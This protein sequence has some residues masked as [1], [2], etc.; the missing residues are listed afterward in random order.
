[1]WLNGVAVL[2]YTLDNADLEG[3]VGL[4]LHPG[5]TMDVRFKNIYLKAL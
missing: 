1:V 5:K 2:D 4:Q 3:P